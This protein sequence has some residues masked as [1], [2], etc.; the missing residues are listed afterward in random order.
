[1]LPRGGANTVG[2]PS[3]ARFAK[4]DKPGT[5]R[6]C[7]GRVGAQQNADTTVVERRFCAA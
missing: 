7:P 1:M 3:F 2:A 6:G 5:P 4:D